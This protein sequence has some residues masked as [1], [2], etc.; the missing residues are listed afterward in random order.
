MP[1]SQDE[2]VA[3]TVGL[4]RCLADPPAILEHARFGLLMNQASVD[5]EFQ[6]AHRLLA[7]RFPRQLKALFGPQHGFWGQQQDNMIET[8]HDIDPVLGV[9]IYSLYAERRKPSPEM[10]GGLDCLVVDLQDVG[11]R[12]YTFIWTLL[13]CLEACAEAGVAVV[14]LDR[15]NPLGGDIVEGPCL[16][17]TYRSF[18]GLHS[19]PMRHALTIGEMAQHLNRALNIGADVHVVR[20][21]GWQRRMHWSATGRV[22]I[23]PSPNLPRVHG[24]DVYPGQVLIEGTN[25]SEGRGTTMPF[26][27]CGAP[28]IEPMRLL[29]EL[30]QYALPGVVFRPVR[31]EP[32]FQ[33][34]QGVSCGGL[35]L[36]VVDRLAFRPYRT[37]LAILTSVRSLWP[38]DFQW[39]MPPYEYE[40]TLMPIDILTGNRDV[41]A[42][43]DV[44]ARPDDI[45]RLAAPDDTWW[46]RVA[47]DLAYDGP[48]WGV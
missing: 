21:Q 8:P 37:T 20:M 48:S 40:T 38:E 30:E 35:C 22:W 26:E 32:T 36:H 43:I 5:T 9:P 46:T 3:V 25:L 42:T 2:R 27:L 18:V 11:T 13:H 24:V 7:A 12:V 19:I 17:Q 41:R 45:A 6:Y 39:R 31:F 16:E 34:A 23:G 15:P 29:E 44:G 4:E 47:D 28:F 1:E 33:K 14:V 10:L